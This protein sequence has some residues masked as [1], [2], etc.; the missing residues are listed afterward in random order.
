MRIENEHP[1]V[2]SF[3]C[4]EPTLFFDEATT[5]VE[6]NLHALFNKLAIRDQIFGDGWN[7]QDI[8]NVGLLT[9][10]A[11]RNI[12]DVPNRM[13]SVVSGFDIAGSLRLS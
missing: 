13:R 1:A 11:E 7:M 10:F 8:L 3:P 5:L 9:F 4:D 12:A 2:S 6:S